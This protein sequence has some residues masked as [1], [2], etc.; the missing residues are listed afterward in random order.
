MKKILL[1]AALLIGSVSGTWAADHRVRVAD[2]QFG[3]RTVRAAV[4]D[5]V[6][7]MWQTGMHTT[8]STSVPKGATPWNAPMDV[9][10]PRFRIR[11]TVPGTYSYQCNFHFAQGMTGRIV[12]Q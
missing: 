8:T 12:V 7:W 11:L 6:S 9:N 5:T 1:L 2:F 3:P 4:G 10:H